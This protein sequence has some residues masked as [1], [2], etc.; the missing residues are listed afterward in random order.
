MFHFGDGG[1]AENVFYDGAVHACDLD[2][3]PHVLYTDLEF[4]GYSFV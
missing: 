3:L 4:A 1:L 2:V